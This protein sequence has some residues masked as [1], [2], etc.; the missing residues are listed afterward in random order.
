MTMRLS[1]RLRLFGS[2]ALI[3]GLSL[4]VVIGLGWSSVVRLEEARLDGRLC[5]EAR[6]LAGFSQYGPVERLVFDLQNKL[7]L[8]SAA[9][10]RLLLQAPGQVPQVYGTWPADLDLTGLPW[11][12]AVSPNGAAVPAD[13]ACRLVSHDHAGQRWRIATSGLDYR[14]VLAVDLAASRN[15]WR[16]LAQYALTVIIPV[17]LLLTA[18]GAWLLSALMLR[19]INRLREAMKSVSQQALDQRLSAAGEDREFRELIAAYNTM[20]DRLQASFQQASRFSA[21]A[22]HELNTPLTILQGRIEQAL[23]LVDPQTDGHA[24]LSDMLDEVGRLAAIT[25]KLLL[26]SHADAGHMAI[27]RTPVDL[28]R[29]LEDLIS[30]A[31]MLVEDRLLSCRVPAGCVVLADALLLRQLFNNLLNNGLRYGR[32]DGWLSV[33]AQVLPGGVAVEFNNACAPIGP[34]QRARFFERFYRG[35]A[36]HSRQL[37]GHGLGLSL[38]REIARAHGGDLTLLDGPADEV[39]LRLWLPVN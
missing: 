35:D 38:C 8:E 21:D 22:A 24:A 37:D 6:R 31:R 18:A 9:Q 10:L 17:A 26:L 19:P 4:A 3:V 14:G 15:E 27:H 2:A 23:N 12:T 7:R 11:Q 34:E 36:A 16:D 25:R 20:L 13:R 33:S 32:S 28:T 1:F 39:A 30:D 5:Q 29:L